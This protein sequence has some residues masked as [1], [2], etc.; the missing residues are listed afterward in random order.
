MSQPVHATQRQAE[1]L[2]GEARQIDEAAPRLDTAP[3]EAGSP[4]SDLN[5]SPSG[6]G[7]GSSSSSS[8]SSRS[9]SRHSGQGRAAASNT[10]AGEAPAEPSAGATAMDETGQQVSAIAGGE[11]KE[12]RESFKDQLASV[13]DYL[14]SCVVDLE[15]R[16]RARLEEINKLDEMFK[17]FTPRD[18]RE[19]PKDIRVF[20]HCWV[21][22]VS[23]GIGKPRLTCQDF[24][25][26]NPGDKNSS[27]DPSNSCP[28]P[29]HST[30]DQVAGDLLALLQL[31]QGEGRSHICVP[32]SSR[33]WR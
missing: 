30:R 24:K 19:L 23:N 14:D 25:K 7:D 18:R 6:S 11:T 33:W 9:R 32:Y 17:A 31:S 16:N 1:N 26:I 21:D 28:T 8:D 15:E 27:E 4:S 3:A 29:G 5:Y 22:K 2:G 13:A 20:G 10:A 12:D